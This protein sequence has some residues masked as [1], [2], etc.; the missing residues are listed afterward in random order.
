MGNDLLSLAVGKDWRRS[1]APTQTQCSV[2]QRAMHGTDKRWIVT[3]RSCFE[4]KGKA[5]EMLRLAT[6][7]FGGGCAQR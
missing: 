5:T 7:G 4:K 3:R 6:G 1:A 2:E